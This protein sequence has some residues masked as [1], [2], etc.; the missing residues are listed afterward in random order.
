[1]EE[2]TLMTLQWVSP[3]SEGQRFCSPLSRI[4]H[5]IVEGLGNVSKHRYL[6]RSRCLSLRHHLARGRGKVDEKPVQTQ[7]FF[8]SPTATPGALE[9]QMNPASQEE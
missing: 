5:I 3:E 1:M 4:G 9:T 8:Y 7:T 6:V 2:S